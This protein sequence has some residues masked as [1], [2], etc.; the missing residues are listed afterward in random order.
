M[1]FLNNYFIDKG[2]QHLCGS[3]MLYGDV[4]DVMQ[5][6]LENS[7]SPIVELN[8]IQLLVTKTPV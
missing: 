1:M 6:S 2:C 7:Q 3:S 8:S 5:N 4:Q